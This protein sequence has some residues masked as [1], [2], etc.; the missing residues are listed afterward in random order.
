MRS[1]EIKDYEEFYWLSE[2][3]W[4]NIIIGEII[5]CMI[6]FECTLLANQALLLLI[7]KS[8]LLPYL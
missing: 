8:D 6:E 1:T 7:A 5:Y 2:C 4:E 3:T